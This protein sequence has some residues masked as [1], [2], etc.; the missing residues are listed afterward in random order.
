MKGL[1][2]GEAIRTPDPNLGKIKNHIQE[3]QKNKLF[4]GV[5][6]YPY[7]ESLANPYL[8]LANYSAA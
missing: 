7:R 3:T 4:S 8:F 6:R 2:A 1:G 5:S